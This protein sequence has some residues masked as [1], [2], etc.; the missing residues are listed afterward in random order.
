MSGEIGLMDKQVNEVKE[1]ILE[2]RPFKNPSLIGYVTRGGSYL[3]AV[4]SLWTDDMKPHDLVAILPGP[5]GGSRVHI[6]YPFVNPDLVQALRN[7]LDDD[8]KEVQA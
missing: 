7:L 6:L 4:P 2:R 3:L 1:Y 8:D 5:I